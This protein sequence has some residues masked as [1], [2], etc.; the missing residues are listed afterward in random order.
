MPHRL[1]SSEFGSKTPN[2][3]NIFSRGLSLG[4]KYQTRE[5]GDSSSSDDV[6]ENDDERK[7]VKKGNRSRRGSEVYALCI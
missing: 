1:N 4:T 5:R 6:D 7:D 2:K 3:L